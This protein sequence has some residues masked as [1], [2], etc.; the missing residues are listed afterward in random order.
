MIGSTESSG[1]RWRD[2]DSAAV[3]IGVG[4][5]S[6]RGRGT[7]VMGVWRVTRN[8]SDLELLLAWRGGDHVA[9][10]QLVRRHFATIHRMFLGKVPDDRLDDLLQRTFLAVVEGRERIYEDA[11]FKAF[12]L[13]VARLQLLRFYRDHERDRRSSQLDTG[14]LASQGGGSP[15]KVMDLRREQSLL[16]RALRKLPLDFQLALELYYWEEL[17]TVEIAEVLEI[18]PGTVRSRLARARDLLARE[19]EGIDVSDELR[20]NTLENLE[21]WARSLRD[22]LHREND[23]R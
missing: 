20:T 7:L 4:A 2:R 21:H 22:A 3:G 5:T 23:S 18:A 14:L 8:A 13:G 19:I 10:N 15:S 17:S 6:A 1:S 16:L 11:G 12:A 9:G